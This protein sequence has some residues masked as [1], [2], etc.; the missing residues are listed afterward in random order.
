MMPRKQLFQIVDDYFDGERARDLAARLTDLYRSPGSWGQLRA[1][2]IIQEALEDAGLEGLEV[3]DHPVDHSWEPV[4]ASLTLLEEDGEIALVDYEDAPTCIAWWSESTAPEGETL[5][6]VDVGTGEYPR[7]FEEEDV[8]GKAVFIHGTSRRPAWWEAARLAI[9]R[10]A[11]GIITDYMLYQIPGIREPHLVPDAVQLLRL[12]VRE[13]PG[14]YAFSISH[15]ASQRL[16]RS[17]AEGSARIHARVEAATGPGKIRNVVASIPGTEKPEESIL[18]CAHASGVRP[19]GNCA[20]GPGLVVELAGAI[21]A[22]IRDGNLPAPRRTLRFLI[23]C[24]GAG[25]AAYLRDHADHVRGLHTA[26]TFCSP[27]HRQDLTASNLMLYRSPDSVPGYINDYLAQLIEESPK[28]ADWIE[29]DGGQ[30][31]PQIRVAMH[32][33]TPWSDNGRFAAEGIQAPLLM[34]W[35]DRY[36][37]S[38]LLT[39]EVIDPIVLRRSALVSGVAGIELANA[40]ARDAIRIARLVASG[41]RRRL[42]R[43]SRHFDENGQDER[44]RPRRMLED[45]LDIDMQGLQRV[46]DLVPEEDRG[47]VAR[48]VERLQRD[49]RGDLDREYEPGRSGCESESSS[50]YPIPRRISRRGQRWAGLSYHDLLRVAEVFRAR[51]PNAGF[52]SLRVVADEVWAFVD[53]SRSVEDIARIVGLEFDVELEPDGVM[54]LLRGLENAGHLML[55]D[56]PSKG[57]NHKEE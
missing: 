25:I 17:I 57:T 30:E 44:S 15:F 32:H 54:M 16:K 19:G 51:D 53:G 23:G 27:G 13:N 42:A 9:Q 4:M 28:E 49:L 40:G 20:E 7:D 3:S 36:F 38:Q 37:H 34:S 52:N 45:R 39:P 21:R 46:L 47:E 26:L 10:G 22:A 2:D 8:Q 56:G 1:M 24:E 33:Y 12:P 5:D 14:V 43:I 48:E 35:P 11:R 29:K 6:V 50:I 41:A 31:L 18:F 55:E